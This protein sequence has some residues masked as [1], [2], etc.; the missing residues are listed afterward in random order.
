MYDFVRDEIVRRYT[1]VILSEYLMSNSTLMT[2][3][4]RIVN[5][6]ERTSF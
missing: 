1:R 6:K 5:R 2:I 4:K 3:P